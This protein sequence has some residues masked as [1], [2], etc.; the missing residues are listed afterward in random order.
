MDK[1]VHFWQ[2]T[3]TQTV[4]HCSPFP[5]SLSSASLNGHLKMILKLIEGQTIGC[6]SSVC[7]GNL[8]NDVDTKPVC[9]PLQRHT[10]FIHSKCPVIRNTEGAMPQGAIQELGNCVLALCNIATTTQRESC[11]NLIS[12]CNYIVTQKDLF[13]VLRCEKSILIFLLHNDSS[14]QCQPSIIIGWINVLPD[15]WAP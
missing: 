11:R 13:C 9:R 4:S 12:R 14:A 2:S 7:L 10:L 6:S 1:G 15:N 5:L 8:R 3:E